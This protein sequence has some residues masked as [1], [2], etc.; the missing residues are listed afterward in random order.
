MIARQLGINTF[1]F[2]W[3]SSLLDAVTRMGRRGYKI[4]DA[5]VCPP[6]FDPISM[7]SLE[8]RG[9]RHEIADMG[10]AIN[11]LNMPSMDQNLASP[12]PE[13]IA[14]T[15]DQYRRL[16][17][18]AVELEVGSVV[19]LPGKAHPL[20][21]PPA[22]DL[23][24]W[25]TESMAAVVGHAKACG[26]RVVIEN[27]PLTILPRASDIAEFIATLG[28]PHVGLCYDVANAAYFGES[29]ALGIGAS[30]DRLAMVHLSDT[31][32]G[33]F[34][35]DPIGQGTV[36]FEATRAALDDIGFDGPVMLEIVSEDP[37]PDAVS[38]HR[39]LVDMGWPA[40]DR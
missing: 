16:I 32:V 40:I 18:A 8:R 2:L 14:Y 33:R 34:R 23:R 39:R 37:E 13:M 26:I 35:H 36:D 6:H 21:S 19:V 31:S 15:I 5:I 24:R 29:P 12:F 30:A 25:M 27:H 3:R 9:L 28:E 20:L 7:S 17:D 11:S 38:S 22:D 4:F 10:A 1:G